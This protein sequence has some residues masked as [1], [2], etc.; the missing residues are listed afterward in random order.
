MIRQVDLFAILRR[1]LGRMDFPAL[2]LAVLVPK[3]AD[4]IV[5]GVRGS[6]PFLVEIV[7]GSMGSRYLFAAFFQVRLQR[8]TQAGQLL[9]AAHLS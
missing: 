7:N 6:M 4:R 3:L 1:V 2:L 9:V 5:V 8:S